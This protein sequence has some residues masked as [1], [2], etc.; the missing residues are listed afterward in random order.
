MALIRSAL[1]LG[2]VALFCATAAAQKTHKDTLLGFQLKPPKGFD[3]VPRS[4]GDTLTV[5]KFAS[6]QKE[7]G[8]SFSGGYIPDFEVWYYPTSRKRDDQSAEDFEA[9]IWSTI[10]SRVGYAEIDEDSVKIAKQ[11][12]VAKHIMPENS[13][14]GYFTAVLP[15]DDGWFVFVGSTLQVRYDKYERDFEKAARSFK[16]IDKERDADREAERAQMS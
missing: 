6:D 14:V 11:K 5:A 16:R 15:Q 2:L 8:K 4:P 3:G 12:C 9:E 10:E 13:Q 7:F 1:V